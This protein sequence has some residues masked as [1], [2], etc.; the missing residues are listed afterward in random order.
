MKA[1]HWKLV[2]LS[3]FAVGAA[4]LFCRIILELRFVH[5]GPWT[6]DPMTGHIHLLQ[7]HAEF[8]YIT[9]QQ[10]WELSLLG[11]ISSMALAVFA[12]AIFQ[13]KR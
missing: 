12:Y 10:R 2:A 5:R 1:A 11:F 6:R 9:G 13:E 8:A 3:S 7:V 4:A